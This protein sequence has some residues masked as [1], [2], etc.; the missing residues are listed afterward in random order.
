MYQELR[1]STGCRAGS[2]PRRKA[3]SM[4]YRTLYVVAGLVAWFYVVL[5]VVTFATRWGG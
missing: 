4:I 1:E 2:R 3:R 5:P